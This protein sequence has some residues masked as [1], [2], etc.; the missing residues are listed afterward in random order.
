MLQRYAASFLHWLYIVSLRIINVYSVPQKFLFPSVDVLFFQ[1]IHTN[2]FKPFVHIVANNTTSSTVDKS[3]YWKM[4]PVSC[5]VWTK[6]FVNKLLWIKIIKQNFL[7]ITAFFASHTKDLMI[8]ETSHSGDLF[9]LHLIQRFSLDCRKW[10]AFRK[11]APLSHNSIKRVKLKRS[12]KC[13]R[14]LCLLYMWLL[15]V[16]FGPMDWPE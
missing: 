13:P 14:G 11:L 16:V 8:A 7:R 9:R 15:R 2:K 10:L 1:C 4:V 3:V 12:R 6:L 5:G